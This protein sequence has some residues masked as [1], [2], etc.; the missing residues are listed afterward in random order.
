MLLLKLS[1]LRVSLK[2]RA[3]Y[4]ALVRETLRRGMIREL[5]KEVIMIIKAL[6]EIVTSKLVLKMT[7][8]F[9]QI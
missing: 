4:L 8:T 5:I 2:L 7:I 6:I 9:L 1:L 3:L